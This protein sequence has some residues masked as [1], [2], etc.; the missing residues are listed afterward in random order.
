MIEHSHCP[1]LRSLNLSSIPIKGPV[2]TALASAIRSNAF[3]VLEELV[4]DRCSLTKESLQHLVLSIMDCHL[5]LLQTLSLA[6]NHLD[7]EAMRILV[8]VLQ[9]SILPSLK[10]LNLSENKIGDEGIE[11]MN[12][13]EEEA[14]LNQVETL[15]LSDN[16]IGNEGAFIL[17][18]MIR[19]KQWKELRDLN[20]D[21]NKFTSVTAVQLR[22]L[23]EMD[24]QLEVL[25][26]SDMT[27][28]RVGVVPQP[29]PKEAEY[30]FSL[31]DLVAEDI[32]HEVS[33]KTC[34]TPT[35]CC[36]C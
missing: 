17:F 34:T 20:L 13:K 11:V 12:D 14:I 33:E 27:K 30:E 2:V 3:I 29:P 22:S 7:S 16:G 10:H 5:Q 31:N 32:V 35:A 28:R 19:H 25:R 15:D 23:L 6:N 24:N 18:D 9:F 1:Q 26:L 21:K 36:V 8:P 4:M